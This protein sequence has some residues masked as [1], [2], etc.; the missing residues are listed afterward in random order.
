MIPGL[1]QWDK[2]PP[3]I[4]PIAQEL[5]YAV[6]VAIKRK[7]KMTNRVFKMRKNKGHGFEV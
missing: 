6:G 2:Y 3:Q 7:K 5:P 4:G 1:T